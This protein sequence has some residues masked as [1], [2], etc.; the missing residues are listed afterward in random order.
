MKWLR[1]SIGY[2]ASPAFR[3]SDAVAS[4][5]FLGGDSHAGKS[6][7]VDSAM[8]LAAVWACVRLVSRTIST[9]P[10]QTFYVDADGNRT[11][12]RDNDLYRLLHDAP[13]ADMTAADFWETMTAHLLLWGNAVAE[14]HRMGG[15]VVALVPLRPDRIFLHVRPDGSLFYRYQDVRQTRELEEADVLHIKGFS[16]DGRWGMS[17]VGCARHSF[18]T[19][20]AADEMA[21]SIFRH[22]MRPSGTLTT[23]QVLDDAGRARL[24]E[25]AKEFTGS[26]NVGKVLVLEQGLT[27]GA[28]SLPPEEAQLLETRQFNIEEVCRWFDVPPFM[29]GHTSKTT[30]WGTGLEQQMIGFLTFSLRPWL[31]K[32]EQAIHA[33]LIPAGQRGRLVVAFNADALMRTDSVGRAALYGA[34]VQNGIRTRNEVRALDNLSPIDGA[35]ELTAQTNLAPLHMLGKTVSAP[36]T[37]AVKLPGGGDP[38]VKQ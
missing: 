21:G 15:R 9:L 25:R 36:D 1:K 24:K 19:A 10:L 28:I 12:A 22:G 11:M 17:P 35:D 14:I 34:Y 8:N 6:V 7:T 33:K 4:C 27:W 23:D 38:P 26:A 30:S 31:T 18:G 32:I 5:Y 37:S 2:V 13:N 3:L 20:L 29:V 16:F